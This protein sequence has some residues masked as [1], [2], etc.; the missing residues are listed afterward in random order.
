MTSQ[1][2]LNRITKLNSRVPFACCETIL[3]GGACAVGN[4]LRPTHTTTRE[5]FKG[6]PSA[7]NLIRDVIGVAIGAKASPLKGVDASMHR[8]TFSMVVDVSSFAIRTT[9]RPIDKL[10]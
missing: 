8:G 10:S 9:T 2:G 7:K 5:V 3:L 4:V 6:L 1:R